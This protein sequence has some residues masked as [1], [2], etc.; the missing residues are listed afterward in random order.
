[1]SAAKGKDEFHLATG[2]VSAWGLKC[3]Y[4]ERAEWMPEAGGKVWLTLW[5][6]HNTYFVRGHHFDG[7][8]LLFW[9]A[10]DADNLTEARKTYRA[11]LRSLKAQLPE[12][13]Q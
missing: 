12:R 5:Q 4:M 3:G 9:K 2:E 13:A 6:E 1:M 11:Q 8:G 10:F 7:Q